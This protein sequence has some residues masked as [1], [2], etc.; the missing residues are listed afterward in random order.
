MKSI[1]SDILSEIVNKYKQFVSSALDTSSDTKETATNR[2]RLVLMHDRTNL[3]PDT[4]EKMRD[5]LLEVISKYVVVD[6]EALDLN[7]AAEGDAIALLASIPIVRAKTK[8]E[9]EE[10]IKALEEKKNQETEETEETEEA[11]SEE[12]E[13]SEETED[14]S[15]EKSEEEETSESESTEE[16]EEEESLDE[17]IAEDLEESDEKVEDEVEEETPTKKSSKKKSSKE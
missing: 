12:E 3:A 1:I 7:L 11:E 17:A 8:E 10:A 16:T 15:T 13:T 9:Q 14:E 2:L 6:E 4:M 5:E